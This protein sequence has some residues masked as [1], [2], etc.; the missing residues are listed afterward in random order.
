[1]LACAVVPPGYYMPFPTIVS[2]C[3]I[4]QYKETVGPDS[5]CTPCGTGVTTAS[6]ASASRNLCSSKLA[7][8]AIS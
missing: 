3:P 2:P 4:G 5:S 6:D 8:A 7:C 1:M